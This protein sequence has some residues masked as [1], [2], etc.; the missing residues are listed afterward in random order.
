[1]N[2]LYVH[3]PFCRRKCPYCHFFSVPYKREYEEEF[4]NALLHE[5][6]QFDNLEN[7][8]LYL[9]GGTPS[10]LSPF[11]LER[12][13][14]VFI[15]SGMREATLEVNPEDEIDFEFLR[16]LGFNRI[17]LAAISFSPETLKYLGRNHTPEDVFKKMNEAKKARFGN[18][19]I[20]I[21]YG[22]PGHSLKKVLRDIKIALSL[23][24][25]HISF[26]LLEIPPY[27]QMGNKKLW[28]DEELESQYKNGRDLI[29]SE[30]LIQYEVSNFAKKGYESIHNLKYW[31]FK[32]FIG[33]GPAAASL[34]DRERWENKKSFRA[35]IGALKRDEK[36]PRTYW[37]LTE[38]EY[39]REKIMMGLRLIK[40]VD[41]SKDNKEIAK[42]YLKRARALERTGLAEVKNQ[43]IRINKDRLFVMNS[44]IVEILGN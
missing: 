27:F 16:S 21:L 34:L 35:Y 23:G 37:K 4:L 39:I 13:A 26:Y 17:S 7:D 36:I 10:I 25:T 32:P 33:L 6:S 29:E 20:D 14:K 19:N 22:I 44:I 43:V 40:G 11:S 24:P 3:I 28:S 31:N 30:G 9:G 18:I 2:G 38:E 12:I 41:L 42:K 15:H 1:M 8:T 5:A